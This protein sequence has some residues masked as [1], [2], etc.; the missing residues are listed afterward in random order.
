[1]KDILKKKDDKKERYNM[2]KKVE[3]SFEEEK[4]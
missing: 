1:M 2:R 4:K 3:A